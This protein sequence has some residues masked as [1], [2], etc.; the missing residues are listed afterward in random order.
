VG[1]EPDVVVHEAARPV[2]GSLPA[3]DDAMLRAALDVARNALAA[4]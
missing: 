1:V 3:K 2:N 4:R